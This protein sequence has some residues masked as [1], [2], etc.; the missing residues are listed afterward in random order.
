LTR[1]FSSHRETIVSVTKL[2]AVAGTAKL[3]SAIDSSVIKAKKE[4]AINAMADRIIQLRASVAAT[5]P[6]A[7]GRKS[8]ISPWRFMLTVCR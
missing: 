3:R 5:C 6:S 4:T 2:N 8:R 7:P 1:S